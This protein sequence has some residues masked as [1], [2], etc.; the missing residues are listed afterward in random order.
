MPFKFQLLLEGGN[1]KNMKIV[2]LG[3]CVAERLVS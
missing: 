2:L 3:L 1:G